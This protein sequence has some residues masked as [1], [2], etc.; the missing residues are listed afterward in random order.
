MGAHFGG[1]MLLFSW[2]FCLCL[3]Y[4]KSC[5][6]HSSFTENKCCWVLRRIRD[7][8]LVFLPTVT[9]PF[10]LK[11]QSNVFRVLSLF[12]LLLSI[13]FM[14]NYKQMLFDNNLTLCFNFDLTTSWYSQFN[15]G[16]K[17][18]YVIIFLCSLFGNFLQIWWVI[19]SPVM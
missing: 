3:M 2:D 5:K 6:L 15:L 7:L 9:W 19:W 14:C 10:K 16:D 4:L 13:F 12:K 17:L 8:Q 1:L 11:L 18:H